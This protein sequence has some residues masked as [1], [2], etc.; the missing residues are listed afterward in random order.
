MDL[1]NALGYADE[2]LRVLIADLGHI[3]IRATGEDLSAIDHYLNGIAV[4]GGD[5][6]VV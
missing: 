1:C 5:G 3:E 2:S 4:P 6:R